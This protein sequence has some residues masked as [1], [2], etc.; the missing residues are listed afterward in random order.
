MQFV[1]ALDAI[2]TLTIVIRENLNHLID[3]AWRIS[4][5]GR[6]ESDNVPDLE[7]WG[8][9]FAFAADILSPLAWPRSAVSNSHK[10]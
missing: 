10:R 3:T 1:G 7:F 6:F 8:H 5:D 2:L 4:N 9:R